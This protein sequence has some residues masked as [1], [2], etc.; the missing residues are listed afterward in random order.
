M[1]C[2]VDTAERGIRT[3][4]IAVIGAGAM[5]AL[6]GGYLSRNNDVLLVDVNEK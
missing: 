6:Y 1:D 2:N 5:G 3:M 4:R